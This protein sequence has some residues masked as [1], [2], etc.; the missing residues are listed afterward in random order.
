MTTLKVINEFINE[1]KTEKKKK[2]GPRW[3]W[4]APVNIPYYQD[5]TEPNL[6]PDKYIKMVPQEMA[7]MVVDME[8]EPLVYALT[9]LMQ[10]LAILKSDLNYALKETAA[11]A[12]HIENN[13]LEDDDN[14]WWVKSTAPFNSLEMLREDIKSRIAAS[15]ERVGV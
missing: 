4:F 12:A 11:I 6:Y 9:S 3:I 5:D 2:Y 8:K 10:E 13:Q 7:D 1:F 14:E 15:V